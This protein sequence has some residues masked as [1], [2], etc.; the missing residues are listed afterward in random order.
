M[1]RVQVRRHAGAC[2][3]LAQ[4][5]IG[6]EMDYLPAGDLAELLKIMPDA[7]FVAAQNLLARLRQVKTPTE[8]NILRRLSRIADKAITD[9]YHSVRAGAS[10]LDL[11]AALTRS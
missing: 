9:A 1:A 5:R 6:I 7:R 4:A 2:R 3:S 10:E 8:I 11:A